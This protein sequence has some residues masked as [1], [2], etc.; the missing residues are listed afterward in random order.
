MVRFGVEPYDASPKFAPAYKALAKALQTHLGCTVK[1]YITQNYTAEIEAMRAN[2]L[3]VGEFGPLGYVFAAKLAKAKPL[4][5]FGSKNGKLSTYM[6]GLWVPNDSTIQT[7]A[8]LKGHSVAFADPASTSG[9]LF[10]RYAMMKAGLNPDKD[11]KIEFAGSHT[12]SMLALVNGKVDA[13]ELN[14]Q[15]EEIAVQAGQFKPSDYR[16]IWH[17]NPIPDDPITVRGNL[18]VAFQKAVKQALFSLTPAETKLVMAEIGSGAAKL[19]PVT[20]HAYQQI[21]DVAAVEHLN[22]KDVG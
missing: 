12:A 10:P 2:K 1:L 21:R 13:S 6:A 5:T 7:V 18:P 8:Q 15:E 14:T 16:E 3:D 9:N 19:V 4:A 20:D 22:L 11:V 17:S